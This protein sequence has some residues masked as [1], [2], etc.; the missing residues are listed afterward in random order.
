M[1]FGSKYKS[2]LTTRILKFLKMEH[3]NSPSYHHHLR[4]EHLQFLSQ[5]EQS[6]FSIVLNFHWKKK[7]YCV[8]DWGRREWDPWSAISRT[9]HSTKTSSPNCEHLNGSSIWKKK[10]NIAT[11][12]LPW[13]A[14]CKNPSC[15]IHT[16]PVCRRIEFTC[17]DTAAREREREFWKQILVIIL[18]FSAIQVARLN[19]GALASSAS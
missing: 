13:C 15:E 17:M 16:I 18:V 6:R 5:R 2:F 3:K 12:Q 8:A 11:S 1:L 9:I 7:G 4:N 10:M 19:A 14:C